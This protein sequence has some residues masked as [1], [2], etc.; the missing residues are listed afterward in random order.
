MKPFKRDESFRYTFKDTFP[1]RF[2]IMLQK[3]NELI[4]TKE[5]SLHILDISPKG[6]RFKT[7]FNLP[8][9]RFDFHMEIYLNMNGHEMVI[10]GHPIWKRPSGTGFMYGFKAAED[11]KTEQF[12]IDTL[13]TFTKEIKKKQ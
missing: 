9:D 6:M 7:K 2:K 13:K 12:I 3:E 5:G 8:V 1:G 11:S 4:S 10:A